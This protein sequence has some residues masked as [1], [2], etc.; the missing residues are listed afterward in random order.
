MTSALIH[1]GPDAQ[2]IWINNQNTLGLG[3][4]RLSIR[5]LSSLG[6]QPMLSSCGRYLI[7]YNGE[8]YSHSE[9]K[10]ELIKEGVKFKSTTDTEI[11]LESISKFGFKE[12]L[13]KLN[14]MFAMAVYDKKEDKL[15]LTRDRI[16]IKPLYYWFSPEGDF[17]FGSEIKQFTTLPGWKAVL[18]KERA[19]DYLYYAVM[20]HT[21]ET[22]FKGVYA[23][24]P[25]NCFAENIAQI[26]T[27]SGA[28]IPL[29]KW[30]I[31]D[32]KDFEGSFDEAKGIFLD[33]FKDAVKLHVRADVPVGSALS[34]GLDSSSIVC[35]VNELLKE[36]NKSELQKTFSSCATDRRFDER[37]WMDV[38]VKES[39]VEAHFIYPKGDD[40]FTRT[41][42]V[43]WH[44]DEPY[45]S[46][47]AFLANHIF[48]EARKNNVFVLLNG[49]GADEYLSGYGSYKKLRLKK[50][51][52]QGQF[53]RLYNE[54][55][56]YKILANI[57]LETIFEYLPKILK[58]WLYA[59]RKRKYFPSDIFTSKW[60]VKKHIHPYVLNKLQLNSIH[61]ISNYKL[62]HDPL[63][64]YLKW[65]DRNSMAHSVEARVP[66][67]EHRLVEFTQSLPVEYLDG[68]GQSKKILVEA[69]KGILPETV[70][71][72]RD[73]KG[74]VS[75]ME[76]W[77]KEDYFIDFINLFKENVLYTK[78][79][80]NDQEALIFFN[81]VKLGKEGAVPDCWRLILFCIWMRIFD[82]E[83]E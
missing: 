39:K 13:L 28:K 38:V 34:G 15:F 74:F 19:L 57:L 68:I 10:E 18:N 29:K 6:N 2:N 55:K 5:D 36:Q 83:L 80:I 27:Y 35:C 31:P 4:T 70:R 79:L 72:R 37:M 20:D 42:S 30:Y 23:V 40:V 25:G 11:I 52:F 61:N 14:G 3:H 24:L 45:E 59:Q 12:T 60:N 26:H 73:K 49:L 48:E 82:V 71:L 33:K 76:R 63:P 53:F 58:G 16:G 44:L 21:E 54:D 66:F 41:K 1:R 43:L 51:F 75:P 56:S 67:L 17:Y 8:I 50:L 64:R 47:S 65:E 81:K 69:M 22:L 77:F 78:G 32:N 62:S 7:V 46:Q 9:L